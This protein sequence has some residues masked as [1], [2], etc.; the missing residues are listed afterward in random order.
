[1]HFTLYPVFLNPF[2]N[3]VNGIN[4]RYLLPVI[5]AALSVLQDNIRVIVS[6]AARGL[7]AHLRQMFHYL[8]TPAYFLPEVQTTEMPKE[9]ASADEAELSFL[10]SSV[11][12][13]PARTD[14][15]FFWIDNDSF[16][17]CPVELTV[18]RNAINTLPVEEPEVNTTVA[19]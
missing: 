10:C 1:M 19:L 4:C 18:L 3:P 5:M 9:S 11:K 7:M 12:F 13:Y 17:A 16:E 6:P 2:E 15:E 14:G 8:L